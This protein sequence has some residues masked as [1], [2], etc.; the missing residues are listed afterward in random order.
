M[1]VKPQIGCGVTWFLLQK[2][3]CVPTLSHSA[4]LQ[5]CKKAETEVTQGTTHASSNTTPTLTSWLTQIQRA[6]RAQHTQTGI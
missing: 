1:S 4:Q 2:E 3:G 5:S 6:A